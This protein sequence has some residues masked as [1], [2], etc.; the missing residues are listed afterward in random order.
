MDTA[1][2]HKA[3]KSFLRTPL[4]LCVLSAF[5]NWDVIMYFSES[6]LSGLLLYRS[7]DIIKPLISIIS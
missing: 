3:R 1:G 4:I 5:F 7:P 2:R 6:Y